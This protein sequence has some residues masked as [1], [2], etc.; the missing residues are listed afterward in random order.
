MKK[1]NFR[2]IFTLV[3]CLGIL[4]GC[5]KND[6]DPDPDP[7]VKQNDQQA[8]A[9]LDASLDNINGMISNKI[10]GGS[11]HRVAAYNLPCGV[12]SVDSST[13]VGGHKIYKFNYGHSSPCGYKYKSG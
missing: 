8:S 9:E 3:L 2:L 4:A 12:I 6:E 10:G 1:L 7:E 13:I 5:K 11:N